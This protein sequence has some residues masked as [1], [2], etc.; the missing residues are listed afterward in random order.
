MLREGFNLAVCLTDLPLRIGRRPVVADASAT[1]GVGLICLPALGARNLVPRTIDAIVRLLDGLVGEPMARGSREADGRR[2]RVGRR[3]A[4]LAA[5]VHR[6]IPDEEDID[7]RFVSAVLRGNL[8]LLVGMVRANRPWRLASGLTKALAAALGAVA[9][10]VVTSDIWRISAS[11]AWPRLVALTLASILG[12]VI[13]LI[14]VHD[15]WERGARR[16][17]E[18]A[19]MF[20]AATALTIALGIVWLYAV[21]FAVAL[22]SAGLVLS[23]GVLEHGVGHAA[24]AGDYVKLA[25]LTASLATIGGALAAGLEDDHAVRQAAYGY[26][27]DRGTAVDR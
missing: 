25:W 18:Q 17:R 5:S 16:R 19:L 13:S 11:L 23:A 6:V 4:G 7:L 15:L 20:N 10:A 24:A 2:G 21:L 14:A 22:V 12:T 26:R 27:P 3:L 9:F 1:H 8:R